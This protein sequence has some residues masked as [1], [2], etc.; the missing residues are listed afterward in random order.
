M[1][2][3]KVLATLNSIYIVNLDYVQ[4]NLLETCTVYIYK[5]NAWL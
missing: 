4:Y 2:Q 3:T 5:I 1:H